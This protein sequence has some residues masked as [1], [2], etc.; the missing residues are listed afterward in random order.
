MSCPIRGARTSGLCDR[1]KMEQR[2][3]RQDRERREAQRASEEDDDT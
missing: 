1:C 3:E 2:L